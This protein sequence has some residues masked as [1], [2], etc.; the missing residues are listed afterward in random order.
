MV[1]GVGKYLDDGQIATTEAHIAIWSCNREAVKSRP[2]R[3][4]K[5]KWRHFRSKTLSK[6]HAAEMINKQEIAR[7]TMQQAM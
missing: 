4:Q 5:F 3:V 6:K 1:A 2:R 7:L